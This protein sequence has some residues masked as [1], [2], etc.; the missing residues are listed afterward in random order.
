M[1][2][3][4]LLPARCS[5]RRVG[6]GS[7]DQ[8]QGLPV[9]RAT[10]DRRTRAPGCGGTPL[11]HRSTGRTRRR[12]ATRGGQRQRAYERCLRE[13]D[14]RVEDAKPA[15]RRRTR[16][17]TGATRK[18]RG[19]AGTSPSRV[20]RRPCATGRGSARSSAKPRR[21]R[22]RR[23]RRRSSQTRHPSPRLHPRRRPRVAAPPPAPP[24]P[25][26]GSRQPTRRRDRNA[27]AE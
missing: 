25:P 27:S 2:K 20:R 26:A 8:R 23:R 4:I 22:R 13:R 21:S 16:A 7:G 5:P 24:A 1:F 19:E 11:Y 14:G 3:R 9:R 6:P 18:A 10:P 17:E 12:E 15:K